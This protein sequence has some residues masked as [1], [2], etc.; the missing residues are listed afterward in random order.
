MR[1]TAPIAVE[2]PATLSKTPP[3]N[4]FAKQFY[5]PPEERLKNGIMDIRGLAFIEKVD[6]ATQTNLAVV[7]DFSNGALRSRGIPKIKTADAMRTWIDE[8]LKTARY[9][10]VEI[11]RLSVADRMGQAKNIYWVGHKTFPSVEAAKA[12]IDSV[13]AQA[14]AQGGGFEQMVEQA[15][16]YVETAE[17]GV[18]VEI[19]TQAQYER[20]EQIALKMLDQLH[21]GTDL[22]GPL[23]GVPSGEPITWQSFGETSWRESNLTKKDYNAQV[24]YW[25]NRLVFKGIRAPLN[26][27]DAFVEETTT[28]ESVGPDYKS[29]LKFYGGLE[30]RPL[31]RSPFLNNFRPW[32]MPL[33]DW[34]KN[35]RLFV[36][37]GNRKAAK[38][39]IE[40]SPDHN[41]VWG[42]QVFYEWG[43][44]L[45][46]AGEGGPDSFPDYLR[47][48]TWGEYYG[49]YHWETTNFSSEKCFNAFI[50]NSSVT[51]G[52]RLP[53]L[54]L[55]Q[56]PINNEFVLMP[57]MRFEH[58][59]NS[60]FSFDYQ[61]RYFVATGVRWMPFRTYAFKENEWLAKTKIFVEWVGV[62]GVF[63]AKQNGD[64]SYTGPIQHDLRVGLNFSSRRY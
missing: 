48:F 40:G 63:N 27:I 15:Q 5:I 62:G 47:D 14:V 49:D 44:D 56:N 60:E 30:W 32:S 58:V 18:P 37:Y 21:I 2:A 20:E 31:A 16:T 36:M 26:T 33:L 35:I 64:S 57:Y 25:T 3:E 53:G 9:Q 23:Q 28:L 1:S 45:P 22:F 59:N 17:G 24:F 50:A 10:G 13:K 7:T 39:E 54:P 61:N 34:A 41:M 51:L 11:K 8:N 42:A 38:G 12:A 43:I 46:G 29:Y 6:L 55:P 4:F 52:I 19:K